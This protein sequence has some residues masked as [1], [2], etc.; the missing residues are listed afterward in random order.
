MEF[1]AEL[2]TPIF[3]IIAVFIAYMGGKSA[4]KEKAKNEKNKEEEKQSD[5]ADR[6]IGNNANLTDADFAAWLQKRAGK[7]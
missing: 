4:G 3:A 6:I 2:L 7:K 1:T 5:N